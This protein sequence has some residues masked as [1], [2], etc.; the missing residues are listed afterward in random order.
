MTSTDKGN[1][2]E[3]RLFLCRIDHAMYRGAAMVVPHEVLPLRHFEFC[4]LASVPMSATTPSGTETSFYGDPVVPNAPVPRGPSA[5]TRAFASISVGETAPA[6]RHLYDCM[7]NCS[8]DV[9]IYGCVR[10][11]TPAGMS[12]MRGGSPACET[13]TASTRMDSWSPNV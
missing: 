8:D 12:A 3:R 9:C 1:R 6:I 5:D 4:R 2:L 13:T 7:A 11:S 10:A